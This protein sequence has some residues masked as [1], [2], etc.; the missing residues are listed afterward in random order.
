MNEVNEPGG[1]AGGLSLST[2]KLGVGWV[3]RHPYYGK[4][5]ISRDAVIAD[6]KQDHLEYYGC[7]AEPSET[8]IE[9]W[10]NEQISWI[11][12]E[13]RGVQIERADWVA[14]EANYM[15]LMAQN[16]DYPDFLDVT[17]N[18]EVRGAARRPA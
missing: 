1:A 13:K 2:A 14:I 5:F 12:I 3:V 9:S 18:A 11:E 17:H 4:W 7:D 10:F 16:P 15:A 6:W 8:D